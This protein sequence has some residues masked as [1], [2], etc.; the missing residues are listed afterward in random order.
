MSGPRARRFRVNFT[1]ETVAGQLA[2]SAGWNRLV[3]RRWERLASLSEVDFAVIHDGL[4][5]SG[6]D[7]RQAITLIIR[8]RSPADG[9]P[10]WRIGTQGQ[11][12]DFLARHRGARIRSV[13][14]RAA[15][16]GGGIEIGILLQDPADRAPCRA[17]RS[18]R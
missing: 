5:G 13:S 15:G 10:L 8:K 7:R 16:P 6:L 2:G 11:T 18:A 14:T 12:E 1:P 3:S 4:R 9:T 17:G